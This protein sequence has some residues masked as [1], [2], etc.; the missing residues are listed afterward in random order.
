[1]DMVCVLSIGTQ[2]H[3]RG[4]KESGR[5]RDRVENRKQKTEIE[6]LHKKGEGI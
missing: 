2:P 3:G 1:M 6:V 5:V 4:E